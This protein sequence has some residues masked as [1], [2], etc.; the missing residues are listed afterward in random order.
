M[1]KQGMCHRNVAH[2]VSTYLAHTQSN[3]YHIFNI[4][5]ILLA[6]LS[7]YLA[8]TDT[9]ITGLIYW[10]FLTRNRSCQHKHQCQLQIPTMSRVKMDV[11][12]VM[13]IHLKLTST[14]WNETYRHSVREDLTTNIT[15]H[16][17]K[18]WFIALILHY[19]S[20]SML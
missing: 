15:D 11:L 17:I 2:L 19:Y 4:G 5:K 13:L 7:V 10:S 1:W 3:H 14:S 6:E 20:F 16:L 9:F 18:R 12:P 8:D